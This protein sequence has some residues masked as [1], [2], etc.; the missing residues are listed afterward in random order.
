MLANGV[1]IGIQTD[2]EM[3]GM[4]TSAFETVDLCTASM[5][6]HLDLMSTLVELLNPSI[7]KAQERENLHLIYFAGQILTFCKNV[8]RS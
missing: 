6:Q 4:D 5:F 2:M 1:S 8:C 7:P 3:S